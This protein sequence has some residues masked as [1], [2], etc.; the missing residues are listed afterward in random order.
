M[1]RVQLGLRSLD[2]DAALVE[3]LRAESADLLNLVAAV[4]ERF[5]VTIAEETIPTIRT[6]REL[7]QHVADQCETTAF[8]AK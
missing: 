1:T 5:C 2:P 3:D 6:A 4:E 7:F 8:P